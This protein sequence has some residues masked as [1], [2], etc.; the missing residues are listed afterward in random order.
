MGKIKAIKTVKL[1]FIFNNYLKS[2]V[3]LLVC[4]VCAFF[5]GGGVGGGDLNRF[6]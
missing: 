6:R 5:L 1:R 3:V 2:A 4:C